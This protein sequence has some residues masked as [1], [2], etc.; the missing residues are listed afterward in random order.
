MISDL[1]GVHSFPVAEAL[2]GDILTLENDVP[3]SKKDI[4]GFSH[5]EG[6]EFVELPS[7]EIDILLSAEFAWSW[8]GMALRG[9]VWDSPTK[10]SAQLRAAPRCAALYLVL[11][12]ILVLCLTLITPKKLYP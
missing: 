9:A 6:V 8:M 12:L 10:L 3:P 2:I 7:K 1:K 4:E 5:L 11:A